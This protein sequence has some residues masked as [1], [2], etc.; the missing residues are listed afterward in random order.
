MRTSKAYVWDNKSYIWD[1]KSY[2]GVNKLWSTKSYLIDTL[3]KC[4]LHFSIVMCVFS[5]NVSIICSLCI[6]AT[7]DGFLQL[8]YN[9]LQT[10][11]I[12]DKST[13]Q[14]SSK[15]KKNFTIWVLLTIRDGTD[16][17]VLQRAFTYRD[18]ICFS[19][20]NS[21][22]PGLPS[23]CRLWH[24]TAVVLTGNGKRCNSRYSF[25]CLTNIQRH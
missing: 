19:I 8:F 5:K 15:I 17:P 21:N 1:M 16:E 9:S 22:S 6:H 23:F 7:M 10:S 25:I 18:V 12:T 3:L 4:Q 2:L 13:V 11:Q 20:M 24:A 14:A